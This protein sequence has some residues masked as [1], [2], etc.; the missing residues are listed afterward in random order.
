[1]AGTVGA[2]GR[3]VVHI[4]VHKQKQLYAEVVVLSG[5]VKLRCRECRRWH[6]LKV[7]R[8]GG[9]DSRALSDYS[10]IEISAP[11]PI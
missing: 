7:I 8:D 9:I 10:E 4:K 1:M 11:P 5:V 6:I 3:T 2:S